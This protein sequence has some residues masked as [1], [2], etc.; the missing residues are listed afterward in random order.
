MELAVNPTPI[1][2]PI[3]RAGGICHLAQLGNWV[4]GFAASGPNDLFSLMV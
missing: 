1:I 4:I 3:K 2:I